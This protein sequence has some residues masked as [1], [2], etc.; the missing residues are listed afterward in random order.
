MA[1]HSSTLAWKIPWTEEPGGLHMVH[2]VA[3]VDTNES[4]YT[5]THTH[6]HTTTWMGLQIII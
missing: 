5:H 1:T 4:T 3:E 2:G 6:T